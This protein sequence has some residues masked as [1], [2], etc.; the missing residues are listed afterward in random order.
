MLIFIIKI[1][2]TSLPNGFCFEVK[3]E[4]AAKIT[5]K[6]AFKLTSKPA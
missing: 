5:V 1:K 4:L 3:V 2:W 6:L